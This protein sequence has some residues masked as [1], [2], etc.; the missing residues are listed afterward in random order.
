MDRYDLIVLGGGLVAGVGAAQLGA[1]TPHVPLAVFTPADNRRGCLHPMPRSFF[2]DRR[3]S[4][5]L[6]SAGRGDRLRLILSPLR[7]Q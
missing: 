7:Q 4:F 3:T 6:R 1:P 5:P 2:E